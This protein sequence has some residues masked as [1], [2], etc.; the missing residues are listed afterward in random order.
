MLEQYLHDAQP[1]KTAEDAFARV[2]EKFAEQTEYHT[3]AVTEAGQGLD[4]VFRFLEE[5]VG[6]SQEMVMFATELTANFYTAWYIQ[7]CGCEAYYRHNQ[8]IL[9]D[10][11]QSKILD[12]IAQM[13]A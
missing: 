2:K 5:S 4:H 13:K 1:E 8:A 3:Q 9:F 7:N 10:D 12:E 11:A 6:E